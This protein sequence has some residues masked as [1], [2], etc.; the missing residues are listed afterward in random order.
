MN[1][2]EINNS[3]LI[4]S[5]TDNKNFSIALKSNYEGQVYVAVYNLLGQQLGFKNINRVGDSY[6]MELNLSNVESGIYIVKVGSQDANA[7]KTGRVIVK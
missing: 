5:S 3:E 1:D 6:R 2:Y 4:I 7:F